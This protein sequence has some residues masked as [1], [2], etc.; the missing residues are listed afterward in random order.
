[1]IQGIFGSEGQLF[2]EL[3]LITNDRLNLPVDAMLDT[4][5]TG[6][7]AIN[8]QDV[9][10]LDW[11]YSGEERLR[12][13]KGYSRFDIYSGKVLLDGQEYDISVYAGDEIIEVLL[14]S[15]WLKILPLVVN[16][17]LGILTLG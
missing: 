15:E 14:G 8:K 4:G 16:Y 12:T 2:F 3:D 7:L 9:N 6:F 17:Q 1:M 10:D 5:F 13:A 11:V